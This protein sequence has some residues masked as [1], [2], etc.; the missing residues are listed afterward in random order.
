[1]PQIIYLKY[2]TTVQQEDI[3]ENINNNFPWKVQ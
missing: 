1:M 3:E 2:S